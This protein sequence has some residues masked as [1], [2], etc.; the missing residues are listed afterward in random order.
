MNIAL[1]LVSIIHLIMYLMHQ[2]YFDLINI[3]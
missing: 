3:K 2:I 1:V